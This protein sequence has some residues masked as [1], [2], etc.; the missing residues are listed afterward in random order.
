MLAE[1]GIRRLFKKRGTLD[2]GSAVVT[3]LLF[4]LLLP[5]NVPSWKVFLGISFGIVFGKEI[6]GGLG[7][8]PFH[9]ALA[10]YAFFLATFSLGPDL[11]QTPSWEGREKIEAFLLL[12]GGLLLLTRRLIYWEI[13]LLYWGSLV[14]AGRGGGPFPSEML[15]SR[16]ILL[17][18]FFFVTDPVTTP[19]SRAGQRWF[20]LGAGLLTVF[21]SMS[22]GILLM[23]ALTP[24]IDDLLGP[25]RRRP[26]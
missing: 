6:F 11:S 17:A 20:A 2:E 5:P 1:T 23:N 7:Q 4:A 19:L 14:L 12:L 3:A 8:N 15:F 10:G 18:G 26:Q 22:S 24:R 16:G 13:P 21:L 9:P 25:R